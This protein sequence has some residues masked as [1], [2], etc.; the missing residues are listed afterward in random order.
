MTS[1]NLCHFYISKKPLLAC[2]TSAN[3]PNF[4]LSAPIG[5][6]FEILKWLK[7]GEVIAEHYKKLWCNY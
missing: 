4:R 2:Q 5:Q 1:P 6:N 7:F 3:L